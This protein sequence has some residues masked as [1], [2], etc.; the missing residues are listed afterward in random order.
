MIAQFIPTSMSQMNDFGNPLMPQWCMANHA[1]RDA[2]P[3]NQRA[4]G[5]LAYC[6]SDQ[7]TYQLLPP[8]WAGTDD[9]WAVF[10]ALNPYAI[11]TFVGF[12]IQGQ[13]NVVAVGTVISGSHT[14]I[15]Q[16][17]NSLSVEPGSIS[18]VDVTRS[19]TIATGLNNTGSHTATIT[20]LEYDMPSS[21]VWRISGLDTK[22]NAF[23]ADFTVQWIA[24]SDVTYYVRTDGSDSNTGLVNDAGGAWLTLQ[25]AALNVAAGD[26]VHVASGTYTGFV[27]GWDTP[28]IG[29]SGHPVSFLA[30][31]AVIVNSKN[32]KTSDAIDVESCSFIVIDGFEVT[33]DGTVTRAGIRISGVGSGNQITNN[34]VTGVGRFGINTGFQTNFLIAL[35]TVTGTLG[36]GGQGTGHGIYSANAGDYG[37]ISANVVHANT[38]DGIHTN[39]DASQG[40]TGIQTFI[41]IEANYLYDNNQSFGGGA[42]N[43]DGLV[44]STIENNL[45]YHE[46]SAGIVLFQQDAAQPSTGNVV[47]SNTVLLGADSPKWAMHL[48]G[49]LG[50][51]GGNFILNNIFGT[52]GNGGSILVASNS[53]GS[54]INYNLYV[55]TG[56][57]AGNQW[58]VEN[59][60]SGDITRENFTAWQALSGN[61][62]ANSLVSLPVDTF[63]SPTTDDYTLAGTSPAL[64]A[65]TSSHAPSVD[66]IGTVRPQGT[67]YDIGCYESLNLPR[68]ISNNPVNNEPN[69][70]VT[71][72]ITITFN[73]TIVSGLSFILKDST[74]TTVPSTLDSTGNPTYVL[75]PNAD[76]SDTQYT[77]HVT[78]ATDGS[79]NTMLADVW[80]FYTIP[81]PE[82]MFGSLGD[83]FDASVWTVS[84]ENFLVNSGF[85][86]VIFSPQV[87]GVITSI[88]FAKYV[89]TATTH[90]V[91]L[92]K[93]NGSG[94]DTLATKASSGET[95]APATQTVDLTTPISVVA[96]DILL[97]CYYKAT[98]VV[99]HFGVTS[100]GGGGDFFF[101]FHSPW[102]NDT[103][104]LIA[105][106]TPSVNGAIYG[107][108]TE[109]L[110][111]NWADFVSANHVSN[112]GVDVI[113][114]AD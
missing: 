98:S 77:V 25:H 8:P 44:N 114:E 30:D 59:P 111:S 82:T 89:D 14:F 28:V 108:T 75:T 34:T 49:A 80:T 26:T 47:T 63:T 103:G 3:D 66:I 96:G 10:S 106:G 90:N 4:E 91:Y 58:G 33:N 88:K 42:I 16:T 20:S 45:I 104:N 60:G 31:A 79:G 112:T 35:N 55:T 67:G 70:P 100:D 64:D 52:S 37:T 56:S 68:I 109:T 107:H 22:G 7:I 83:F 57:F 27:M 65:G 46:H 76:L 73:E 51:A 5:M 1:D 102:V 105:E 93:K 113:F 13:A 94:I 48:A 24:T 29:A 2:I 40:G 92:L 43:A 11:P 74:D 36:S 23:S 38:G 62:D 110:P 54:T 18:I 41:T 17:T 15:W 78:G 53:F 84:N 101:F 87:N 72:A 19:I 99:P 95:S 39:G 69:V 50:A 32:N 81:V 85:I 86:G 71:T 12:A 97:A 9:D 21:N 6:R 61:P